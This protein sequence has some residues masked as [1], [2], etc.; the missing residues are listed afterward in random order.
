MERSGGAEPFTRKEDRKGRESV[1]METSSIFTTAPGLAQ[2]R[3][4]SLAQPDCDAWHPTPALWGTAAPTMT[5]LASYQHFTPLNSGVRSMDPPKI[6]HASSGPVELTPE[7]GLAVQPS[8]A[9]AVR[10]SIKVSEETEE[11]ESKLVIP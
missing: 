3:M 6:T 1:E 4:L 9:V 7:G 2:G 5:P 8:S 10:V 11:K